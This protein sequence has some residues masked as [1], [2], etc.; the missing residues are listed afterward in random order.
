MKHVHLFAT[1]LLL[2]SVLGACAS[3]VPPPVPLGTPLYTQFTLHHEKGVYRTT[4]YRRGVLLP[5]NSEVTLDDM[6][7]RAIVVRLKGS[8]QRLKI[9]N[10]PKHTFQSVEQ[11]FHEVLGAEPVDL[12]GFFDTEREAIAAGRA[13]PGMSRESVSIAL[14]PPPASGTPNRAVSEWVY[15]SNRWSR[16]AVQFDADGRVITSG[17]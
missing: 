7:S 12:S 16:F 4:N 11:A 8:G 3:P 2:L 15:W 14:G 17:R 9:E 10:M 13:E 1:A 6:S 5:V